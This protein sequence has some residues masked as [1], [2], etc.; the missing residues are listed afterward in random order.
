[1]AKVYKMVGSYTVLMDELQKN[2]I[3]GLRSTDEVLEYYKSI[4]F[5]KSC[6]YAKHKE[7][8]IKERLALPV[9]IDESA[10]A[11]EKVRSDT[12]A[13]LDRTLDELKE[14]REILLAENNSILLRIQNYV[15]RL[16]L[17]YR[18]KRFASKIDSTLAIACE[19]YYADLN[20]K[21]NRLNRLNNDFDNAILESCASVIREFD[22]HHSVISSLRPYVYG[23]I[24]ELKVANILRC[25]PEG[26]TLI[27]DLS[28]EF[29]E[30]L[31]FKQENQYISSVQIDH[32]LITQAGVF[33]IETKNWSERPANDQSVFS[34][35]N[36]VR[37]AGFALYVL[38]SDPSVVFG[39]SHLWG[40]QKIPVRNLVV[41]TGH[42]P[43]GEYQFVKMLG[44]QE[45]EGY[46]RY[47]KPVYSVEDANKIADFFV[48]RYVGE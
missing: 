18:I 29:N 10:A 16:V 11:V 5:E 32:L 47:F 45:L 6:V 1:M 42:K 33:V 20:Y 24:G 15:K 28:I 21:V 37:R 40:N 35:V 7:Q 17:D 44:V 25:L 48:E 39:R 26:C 27:N 3:T 36:Q 41:F 2:E 46:V 8:L 34:P 12:Q 23:A 13:S 14:K 30:P 22:R 38:L 43:L 9:E 19:S 4:D 31:Y